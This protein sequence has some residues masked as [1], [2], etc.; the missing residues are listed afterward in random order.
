L[1]LTACFWGDEYDVEHIVGDYY[2]SGLD[3]SWGKP[4][5]AVY[6]HFDDEEWGLA[7]ALLP[8]TL[9]AVGANEKCIIMLTT[10][11]QRQ[12]YVAQIVAGADRAVA[13]ENIF[14]PFDKPAFT[15]KLKEV[16]GDTLVSFTHR[17]ETL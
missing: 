6:L 17:Y 5:S 3:G 10:A 16:N 2:V 8:Q 11:P 12:Y 13:R 15:Q 7:D 1:A 9:S 4:M 14:G